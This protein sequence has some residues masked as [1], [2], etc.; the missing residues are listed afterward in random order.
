MKRTIE[1][2]TRWT[3][4][5]YGVKLA[6]GHYRMVTATELNQEQLFIGKPVA[7]QECGTTE[8]KEHY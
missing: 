1:R 3:G 5:H 8:T 6:C 7:C 4:K 2:I